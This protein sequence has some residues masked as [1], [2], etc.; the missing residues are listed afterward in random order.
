MCDIFGVNTHFKMI[1]KLVKLKSDTYK[2]CHDKTFN[3]YSFSAKRQC[4]LPKIGLYLVHQSQF[5][6]I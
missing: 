1:T 2:S 5:I 4:W 6:T 3:F